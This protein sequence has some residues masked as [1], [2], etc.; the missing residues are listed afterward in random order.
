MT[1]NR[2]HGT[3][4]GVDV[5]S[6]EAVRF[7]LVLLLLSCQE[8]IADGRLRQAFDEEKAR[9]GLQNCC[10]DVYRQYLSFKN[11]CRGAP[12]GKTPKDTSL[13]TY[14]VC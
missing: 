9:L 12:L 2:S 6:T 11:V 13:L 8:P 14:F 10:E 4:K 1:V 7:V 5:N 3:C